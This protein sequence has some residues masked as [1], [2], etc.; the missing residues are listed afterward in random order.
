MNPAAD[1]PDGLPAPL[2]ELHLHLEGTLEPGTI[3]ELAR[4]NATPLPY[5]DVDDLAGRYRF[6]DLQSFLDL[7][8][9]NMATLR[10]RGD[11]EEMAWRYLV[12]A[13]TA[14]VRHAEVFVD[15]QAHTA[16]G[17]PASTVLRGVDDALRRATEDLGISGAVIVCAL[18]D[19]PA[20]EALE[21]LDTCLA[22]GVP[23]LGIGLDSAEAGHPPADF[24]EVFDVAAQ[25]GLRRVCHAGEEGPPDYI[26]QALDLL[27][28]ERIDHG[29]RCLEDPALVARLASERVPLTV[30]PLSNVRL[31]VVGELAEHPLRR[32]L[33]SGLMVC[34][35]SDDPA[36]F[37]GYLDDNLRACADALTLSP[38][39]LH[40]LA[41][42]SVNASFAPEPRKR[43]LLEQ[44]TA[45]RA[46]A[47]RQPA[48]T[49]VV[50]SPGQP[51]PL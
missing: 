11:F 23:I 33:D 15:P 42:N 36:Y 18:R 47:P 24:A 27:G 32:M 14:G 21:M 20:T 31:R 16:R 17:V 22:T 10:S 50:R 44:L 7:Y 9:A 25:A 41:A 13:R 46:P 39:E 43:E 29:V 5:A 26:R 28:A 12:R 3:F 2:A 19:R 38:A 6:S 45:W 49:P 37:G 40:T 1:R 48:T 4:R 35:N 51:E 34:V 8:Y 30:C